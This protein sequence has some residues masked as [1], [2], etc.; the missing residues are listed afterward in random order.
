MCSL[1]LFVPGCSRVPY[2][3]GKGG[4]GSYWPPTLKSEADKL[5]IGKLVNV[6]INLNNLKTKVNNLDVGKLKMIPVDLK[7]IGNVVKNQVVK[8]TK[9][10]ALKTQVK[11]LKNKFPDG[12]TFIHINH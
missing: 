7:K 11:N 6:L 12:T 1:T 5:D 3:S 8:N 9:F 4:G 10:N 2:L